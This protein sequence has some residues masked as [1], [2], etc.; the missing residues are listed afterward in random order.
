[1]IVLMQITTINLYVLANQTLTEN[2][3]KFKSSTQEY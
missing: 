3:K 2:Y 1:M